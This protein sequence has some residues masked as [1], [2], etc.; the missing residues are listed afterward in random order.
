MTF[1]AVKPTLVLLP[2]TLCDGRMFTR[3]LRALRPHAAVQCASYRHLRDVHDWATRLLRDLPPTFSVAGFSLGG[4]LALE[5]LRRAPERIERLALIG[6]NAQAGS[7]K[8][9]RRSA[10]LH[11]L[12]LA[13]G[14]A[15][16]AQ[17]VKPA[18][19]H[20]EAKRRAHQDLVLQ[21]A[22]Q[23]PQRSAFAQ[24]DWAAQRPA[25]F[26]A[27]KAFKGPVLGIAGAHDRL[28]PPVW[29]RAMQN[30]Q[31]AIRRIELAR[32][33]H[34]VPLESPAQLNC[35]LIRWLNIPLAQ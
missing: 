21:M 30:A 24:F 10:W 32:C 31:P 29:Q 17:H 22:L 33:G 27:L 34:F 1:V 25:G 5:L 2:G 19:F 28:C 7:A 14:A 16:V 18:Y 12:Y 23:T 11:K 20:F 6:S 9:Q 4:L 35:A 26:A 8:G 3:Q 15:V 13:R